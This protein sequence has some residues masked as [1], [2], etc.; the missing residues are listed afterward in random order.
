MCVVN[1]S[2]FA[3]CVSGSVCVCICG[4]NQRYTSDH[5]EEILV[6]HEATILAINCIPLVAV[7]DNYTN[8]ITEDGDKDSGFCS[9]NV[10]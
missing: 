10:V 3:L 1:I 5:T 4:R 9:K 6:L 8:T 7:S 2:L